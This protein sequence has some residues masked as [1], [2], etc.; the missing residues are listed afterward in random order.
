[1]ETVVDRSDLTGKTI[2]DYRIMRRLGEGGMG[3]VYLS[4][5]ISLKRP[6]ALKILK[7][8]LSANASAL[9]RF[10][11]EA[12]AVAKASHPNIVQ[13]YAI[14]DLN[15]LPYMALEYVEG[16]TLRDYL[17]K[18]GP[19]TMALAFS[20]MRQGAAAL[21][22]AAELGIIHRDIKPENILLTR[23]G[24]VKVADFG[25]S[26]CL[27]GDQ[28]PLNLT[29]TGVTM[30]TPLYMSPEQVQ[31]K[32]LDPRTD[33][34]SFGVTCYHMLTGAPPF[35]GQTAF[36]VALQHVQTQPEPLAS[37]RPDLPADL[38]AIVHKMMAKNPDDRYST[39]RE[40]LRDISK[41]RERSDGKDVPAAGQTAT[42]A[43]VPPVARP[44]RRWIRILAGTVILALAGGALAGWFTRP[45][46]KE[47]AS[48][49]VE[50]EIPDAAPETPSIAKQ[51]EQLLWSQIKEALAQNG[52]PR[53]QGTLRALQLAVLYFEQDRLDDAD[54]LFA[55]LG[56]QQK[57][58]E[59]VILGQMG[60]A[61]VLALRNQAPESTAIFENLIASRDP[62]FSR[63]V[64]MINRSPAFLKWM[65]KALDFNAANLVSVNKSL[66]PELEALRK[67]RPI[68][69]KPAPSG[70]NRPAGKPM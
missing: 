57:T 8:E 25:L 35:K 69:V 59:P 39:A 10:K 67:T 7:S 60:H 13:V 1:M 3:Q 55:W 62:G 19:P 51:R 28:P 14:G 40:L 53:P 44:R 5:Q 65:V 6:V 48:T 68:P 41:L 17:A 36:D 33:I 63:L 58:K 61:M 45:P 52:T 47:V 43:L 29:Q 2:G 18:K 26:R 37:V 64:L 12:E 54:H 70:P 42:T 32:S 31:G 11:A 30:G 66:S 16:F 49:T 22:R 38:C 4:E 50:P 21:Q 23:K 46:A 15:G 20:I 9:Q 34:Y 27:A 24:A 56:E